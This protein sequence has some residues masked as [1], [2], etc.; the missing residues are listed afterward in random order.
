MVHPYISSFKEVIQ[1]VLLWVLRLKGKKRLRVLMGEAI[2]TLY[3]Y[4]PLMQKILCKWQ[5]ILYLVVGHLRHLL[6]F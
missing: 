4:K 5:S 6:E 2:T 1:E 3:L